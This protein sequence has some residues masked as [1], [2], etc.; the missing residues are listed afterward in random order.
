[1]A[2]VHGFFVVSEAEGEKSNTMVIHVPR[3]SHRIH[4]RRRRR[5]GPSYDN[6]LKS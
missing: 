2:P 5:S 4:L 3:S 1:M 6:D